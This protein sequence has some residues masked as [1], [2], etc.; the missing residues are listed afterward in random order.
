MKKIHSPSHVD[1]RAVVEDGVEIGPGA[2]VGPNV[3]IGSGTHVLPNAYID[4]WTEIGRDCRI[5][6]GAVVGHEPQDKG[7]KGGES[8]L[9]L[10]D[11]N[12]VREYA[13]IHR[14]TEAG[15]STVV[16]NDDLFMAYA[17][18][19]HNCRIGNGAI[20]ASCA[21]LAGF[22]EVGDQ[23]VISGGVVVHQF[24]RIGRLAMI[25]GNSRVARDVPPF[26]LLEGSSAIRSLNRVGLK[27]AGISAES[28]GALKDVFRVYFR[29][30]RTR[31]EALELLERESAAMPPEAQA[32][33]RF[34]QESK[35][36]VCRFV[37]YR[38]AAGAA[39]DGD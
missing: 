11:R 25:G 10:G 20:V 35:R 38:S 39:D 32:F 3:R 28:L 2:F 5:H 26:T 15:T 4:G 23:A 16:G 17:H 19:A 24:S 30:G 33:V 14:G 1:P 22:V 13:T 8:F 37:R 18:L 36:G 9:R 12:V 31:A 27:R 7:F 21:L 34:V 29:S 6:V